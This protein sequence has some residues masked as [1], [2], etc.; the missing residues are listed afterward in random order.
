M[1]GNVLRVSNSQESICFFAF[2]YILK[3]KRGRMN[4]K[5]DL[6]DLLIIDN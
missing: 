6:L 4:V 5:A 2:I 3:K 1:M